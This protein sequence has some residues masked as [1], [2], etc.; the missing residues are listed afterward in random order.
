MSSHKIGRITGC[1]PP[2]QYNSYTVSD[3]I[4]RDDDEI[5][6]QKNEI[7]FEIILSSSQTTIRQETLAVPST[8]FLS[9][10]IGGLGLVILFVTL[11]LPTFGTQQ[12]H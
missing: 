8:S 10:F 7:W 9:E 2:C 4:T 6:I 12:K 5:M 1:N 3:T 11:L